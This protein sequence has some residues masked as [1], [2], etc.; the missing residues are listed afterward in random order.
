[1][2]ESVTLPLTGSPAE[3][4]KKPWYGIRD[5]ISC[6]W[7]SERINPEVATINRMRFLSILSTL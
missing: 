2:K 4:C 3:S 1:L 6:A 5:G 7:T